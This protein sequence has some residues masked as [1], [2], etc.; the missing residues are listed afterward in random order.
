MAGVTTAWL[1]ETWQ[2]RSDPPADF[3]GSLV[4]AVAAAVTPLTVT[5]AVLAIS[6]DFDVFFHTHRTYSHS[7]G[8]A[9]IVW[10]VVAIVAWRLRLPVVKVASVCAAAYASHVLLDWLGRDD[11]AVGGVMALWP[12]T[13][14]YYRSGLNLFMEIGGHP[15]AVMRHPAVGFLRIVAENREALF[16]EVLV[17]GP[18]FLL[19][20]KLRLK[21]WR[22]PEGEVSLWATRRGTV[23]TPRLS[24]ARVRQNDH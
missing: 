18:L 10:V 21:R 7:L 9:G 2:R 15:R 6:P 13:T 17:L 24:R 19:A 23:V 20:M 16:R 5:C 1:A 12:L 22:K 14:D 3:N 8:A 4:D 11:S